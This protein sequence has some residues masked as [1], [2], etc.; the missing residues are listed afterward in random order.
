MDDAIRDLIRY[1]M[2]KA[3]EELS[4]SKELLDKNLFAKSINCSY[5]SMFHATRALLAVKKIDSK[6]H[7]G[8]I[9]LFNSNFIIS[10]EVQSQYYKFLSGGFN[11]RLQSDYHDF[12]IASRINAEGQINNAEKFLEMVKIYLSKYLGN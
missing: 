11:N 5:Y 9:K 2:E 10:G 12:Y 8:V 3:E 7:S 6:K 4:L 1:R